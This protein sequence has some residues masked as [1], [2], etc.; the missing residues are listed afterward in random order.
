MIKKTILA[1]SIQLL[2]TSC[3]MNEAPDKVLMKNQKEVFESISNFALDNSTWE[4][5]WN[6]KLDIWKETW[7]KTNINLGYILN[8]DSEN[9]KTWW[10]LSWEITWISSW[11]GKNAINFDLD[12]VNTDKKLYTKINKKIDF[13]LWGLIWME[14][15][16]INSLT[17]KWF[18]L[19]L[20]S[21]NTFSV[22]KYTDLIDIVNKYQ[23]LKL[24]KK[25][26]DKKFYNYDVTINP[27]NLANIAND[28]STVLYWSW[29]K[30]EDRKM[31]IDDLNK[32][33][34]KWN[35]KID[36]KNK[37]YFS[38]SS[39]IEKTSVKIENNKEILYLNISDEWNKNWFSIEFKK[40]WAT[41]NGKISIKED[42]KDVTTW[43]FVLKLEKGNINVKWKL[44]I[45]QKTFSPTWEEKSEK[46]TSNFDVNI[47]T[48][49]D[50]KITVEEPKDAKN[51]QEVIM[52]MLWLW[53]AINNS[54]Q[55]G[56]G[57]INNLTWSIEKNISTQTGKIDIK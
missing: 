5:K 33:N 21:G 45:S 17:S 42:G 13:D 44:N 57:A 9:K 12:F 32:S 47:A 10:S 8:V 37:K 16:D 23:I 29:I 26:E 24:V 7:E 20:P 55:E 40:D 27:E 28:Y 43:D 51:I 1:I 34:F 53:W 31:L 35:I 48:D 25:N 11:T 14:W 36:P 54:L 38:F 3:G 49:K 41:F 22:K 15:I 30:S 39:N 4:Q 19:D 18:Y 46:V 2:I 6:V 50:K 52:Q 56:T